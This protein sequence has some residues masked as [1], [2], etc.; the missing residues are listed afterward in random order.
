MNWE[1]P[2]RPCLIRMSDDR[3]RR[4]PHKRLQDLLAKSTEPDCRQQKEA[5]NPLLL[6]ASQDQQESISCRVSFFLSTKW[7]NKIYFLGHLGVLTVLISVKY[8]VQYDTYNRM[9]VLDRIMPCQRR[10]HSNPWN[11][12]LT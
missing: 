1:N 5:Q 2:W 6:M 4:A 10:L 7:S 9:A 8:L 3:D 12:L 11:V